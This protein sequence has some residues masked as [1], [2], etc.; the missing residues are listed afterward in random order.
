M[1]K[2]YTAG[3]MIWPFDGSLALLDI[4]RGVRVFCGGIKSGNWV[5]LNGAQAVYYEVVDSAGEFGA[6]E[7]SVLGQWHGWHDE[8]RLRWLRIFRRRMSPLKL[9]RHSFYCD[10]P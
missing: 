9:L 2:I 8:C 4:V 7:F 3:M 5:T 1:L 10:G 6:T